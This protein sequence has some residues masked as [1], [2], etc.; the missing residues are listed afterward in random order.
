MLLVGYRTKLALAASWLLLYSVQARFPMLLQGGDVLL[1]CL[2]VWLMFLPLDHCW[3]W[4]APRSTPATGAAQRIVSLAT[5]GL[6]VQLACMY[7]FSALLKTSPLWLE[8]FH[9]TYFAL[10][11]DHFTSPFGYLLAEYPRL[12]QGI[13]AITLAVEL[14]G[15]MLL[16]VPWR[17]LRW[18]VPC[19]FI[20]FHA[21]LVACLDL[22]TFPWICI[23]YWAALLP[24]PFWHGVS[25]LVQRYMPSQSTLP[26]E[27][28]TTT[29]VPL[30]VYGSRELN[31]VAGFLLL[32]V[33]LLNIGKLRHPFATV[34][35]APLSYVAKLTGLNQ[36]WNMFA[37]GPYQYSSWLRIEGEQADGT[38]VNLFAPH[39]PL[40]DQRP[41]YVSG[42]YPTQY[43]RRCLVMAFEF[44][45]PV[46]Q[47][48]VLRY[49]TQQWNAK[50]HGAQQVVKARLVHMVEPLGDPL[51][52]PAESRPVERRVLQELALNPAPLPNAE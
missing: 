7:F 32:Y 24:S 9:A 23:V 11:I 26:S 15:P 10:R 39:R 12:L 37:P 22:G 18:I 47:Q 17:P 4:S 3:S 14:L 33:L 35:P 41:D 49:F 48:G 2:L 38:L 5:T 31:L 16:F 6:L 8:N 13:T 25:T 29:H 30:R 34:G 50:H 51:R 45:E 52:R 19:T 42:Q 43:W 21:G 46:H 20:G 1:R 27:Q 28:R 44:G 36:Y 40:D